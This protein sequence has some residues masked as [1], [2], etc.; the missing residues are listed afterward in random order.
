MANQTLPLSTPDSTTEESLE[1]M[2]PQ[3]EKA[4][5]K[6]KSD[7]DLGNDQKRRPGADESLVMVQDRKVIISMYSVF[8]TSSSY[9][10]L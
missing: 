8:K 2:I 6:R 1:M 10:K 5:L 3:E 4:P 9:F 7:E